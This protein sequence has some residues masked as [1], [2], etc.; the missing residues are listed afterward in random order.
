MQK[1]TKTLTTIL[2]K[3]RPQ[4][5]WF[6]MGEAV[7]LVQEIDKI[8]KETDVADLA[9]RTADFLQF[10]GLENTCNLYVELRDTL[11]G[12]KNS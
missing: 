5:E 12:T 10:R 3:A 7:R 8:D 2:K 6:A 4:I 1:N 9:K 11:L